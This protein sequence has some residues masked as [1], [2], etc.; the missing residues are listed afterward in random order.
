MTALIGGESFRAFGV[1]PAAGR[2]VRMGRPKL[3]LPWGPEGRTLVEAVV[4]AWRTAGIETLVATVHRDD[5]RLAEVLRDAGVDVVVPSEPPPDMK[6]SIAVALNRIEATHHPQARDVWLTAPADMPELSP[7]VVRRL[8]A[9]HDVGRPA[10]LRPVHAD[11][12]GHPLLLPWSAAAEVERLPANRGID[13]LWERL[14][15]FDVS[16]EADC[17]PPDVDTPGDYDRLRARRSPAGP[18]DG[19]SNA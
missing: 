19:G 8:I 6:A 4:A 18:S 17:L 7:A 13:A 15:C 10:I 1:L 14:P 12:R 3:L 5:L 2:S 9:A 11:R 16:C